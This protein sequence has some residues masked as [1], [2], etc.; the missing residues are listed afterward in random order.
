MD[1]FNFVH[2]KNYFNCFF[3]EGNFYHTIF[4]KIL[5]NFLC[6]FDIFKR[7]RSVPLVH[8]KKNQA[9]YIMQ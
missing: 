8:S 6:S 3:V 5:K 1:E 2:D 9:L 4:D 7:A